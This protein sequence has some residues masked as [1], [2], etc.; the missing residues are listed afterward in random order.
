MNSKSNK[1]ETS[2]DKKNNK[3]F[4]IKESYKDFVTFDE[5]E[6]QKI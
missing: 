3:P 5:T 4:E 2:C 1:N 6:Q